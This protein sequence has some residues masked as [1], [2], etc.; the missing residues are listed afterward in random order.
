MPTTSTATVGVKTMDQWRDFVRSRYSRETQF[1]NLE[2]RGCGVNGFTVADLA[3]A[4]N[5][6]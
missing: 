6:R 4:A 5:G 3:F 2:V 1:L